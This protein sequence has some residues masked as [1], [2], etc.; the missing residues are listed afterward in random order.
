MMHLQT[1]VDRS[2]SEIGE[3]VLANSLGPDAA[4]V[5]R[6]CSAL[7]YHRVG[8]PRPGTPPALTVLPEEFERQIRRLVQWGYIGIRPTD[9]LSWSNGSRQ[10]VRKPILITFDDAYADT[11][12]F[13]LPVILQYGFSAAVYVVTGRVGKTNTWDEAEGSAALNL[14]TEEQIRSWTKRGI[15]FGAHSRTH[16]DLTKLSAEELEGEVAGSKQDLAFLLGAPVLSFA[17]PYGAYNQAV[18]NTVRKEFAL[19]FTIQ[20]GMIRAHHDPHLLRRACVSPTTSSIEFAVDARFGGGFKWLR[21]LRARLA[22]RTRL[23]RAIKW[24]TSS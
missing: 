21:D 22:L 8:P 11:A 1:T 16:P 5:K 3:P 15:E 18:Y 10:L 19:A 9:W 7:M 14:M 23:A 13:A 17:Y 20:E 4:G 2:A 24:L 12:D 6:E